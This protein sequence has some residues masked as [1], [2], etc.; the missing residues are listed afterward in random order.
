MRVRHVEYPLS[1]L[2]MDLNISYFVPLLQILH[3]FTPRGYR[4]ISNI[5]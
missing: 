4:F 1:V 2:S 3:T 5:S